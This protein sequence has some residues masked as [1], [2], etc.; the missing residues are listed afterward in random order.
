MQ[1]DDDFSFIRN[2]LDEDLAEE[3]QLFTYLANKR[4][5]VKVLK[6]DINEL[7]EELLSPRFNYSAPRISVVEMASDGSLMLS[8]DYETDGTG[9]DL[10]RAQNVLAYIHRVWRRKVSLRTIDSKENEI[11]LTEGEKD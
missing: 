10:V 7:K 8:H 2:H 5:E 11:V 4:G 9:L 6:S 1:E 3:L